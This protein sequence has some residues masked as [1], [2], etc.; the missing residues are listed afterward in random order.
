MPNLGRAYATGVPVPHHPGGFV[1][2]L[3]P[4]LQGQTHVGTC[5]EGFRHHT[6]AV[7]PCDDGGWF[8]YM[9]GWAG[10]RGPGDDEHA[11]RAIGYVLTREPIVRQLEFDF[12]IP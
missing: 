6:G 4:P 1:Y 9:P 8:H 11:L 12:A 3:E 7:F 5:R 2:K 10:Y